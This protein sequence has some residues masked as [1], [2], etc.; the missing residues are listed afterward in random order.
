MGLSRTQLALVATTLLGVGVFIFVFVRDQQDSTNSDT[1]EVSDQS[2]ILDTDDTK[3]LTPNQELEQENQNQVDTP[4]PEDDQ[5][6]KA[7]VTIVTE[8]PLIYTGFGHNEL[9]PL[10]TGQATSTTCTTDPNVICQITATK[11]GTGTVH[12]FEAITT[13]SE[14]VARWTWTGGN[15]LTSGAWELLATAGDKSSD[16]ETIYVE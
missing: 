9:R 6:S 12:T 7:P 2:E 8:K 14:G 11:V 5:P 13:D 10:P 16:K 4:R 1:T 3:P 15:E